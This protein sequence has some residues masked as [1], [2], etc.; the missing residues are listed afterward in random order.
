MYVIIKFKKRVLILI[1]C[2]L[3]FIKLICDLF[4]I[5]L[6]VDKEIKC[7]FLRVFEICVYLVFKIE[8]VILGFFIR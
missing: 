3:N 4:L 7:K 1:C 5:L 8:I 2:L 6:Y